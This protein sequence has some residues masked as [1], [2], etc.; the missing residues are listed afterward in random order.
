MSA[1]CVSRKN[2]DDP[3]DREIVAFSKAKKLKEQEAA[4]ARI[5]ELYAQVSDM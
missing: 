1:R 3:S 4:E 2:R 5:E